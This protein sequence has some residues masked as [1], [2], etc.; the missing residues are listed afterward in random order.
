MESTSPDMVS[1]RAAGRFHSRGAAGV[2]V[3]LLGPLRFPSVVDVSKFI[4]RAEQEVKRRNFDHAMS[5]YREILNLD[6][7]CGEARSGARRAAFK[8]FEKRYPSAL[9]RGAL[10]LPV[11]LMLPFARLFRAHQWTANLCES[12]LSRDPKNPKLNHRLGHALLALGHRKGALAAFET[13]AEFDNRDSESLKIHGRLYADQK[14]L[15][16]ALECY[17]KALNINPRDQ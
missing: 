12:A 9:E 8:K 16:K 7:D 11:N 13:V 14:E 6:P 10:N 5:L 1:A 2:L 15:E 17:E 4:E 3:R